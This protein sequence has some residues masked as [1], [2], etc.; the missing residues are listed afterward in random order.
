MPD[1]EEVALLKRCQEGD[2]D[3]FQSIVQR[4]QRRTYWIAN[5]MINS[6]EKAQ[7]ISQEAFLRVYR[8]IHRFDLKKNFYTWLYQIVTNLCIDHLR[9]QK[10]NPL[11]ALDE[12]I[13]IPDSKRGPLGIVEASDLGGKVRRVLDT[14]PPK[15]SSVLV[16]RDIQGFDC[17]EISEILGA[18]NA[19]V[20]WRLHRARKMFKAGW[21]G[22]ALEVP[23]DE[24]T[25]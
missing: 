9:K 15:Y 5:H 12:S 13:G 17:K 1:P 11:G 22:S 25:G 21:E 18:T 14:L 10:R 16:L 7:D 24:E 6:Y 3:A 4:Y 19:T 20:R 8:N 23:E 2:Q